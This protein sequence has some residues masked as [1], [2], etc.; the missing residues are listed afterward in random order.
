V[1]KHTVELCRDLETEDFVVQPHWFV[2]PPKWHLGHTTWFFDRF[3][4]QKLLGKKPYREDF[5]WVFNSYYESQG[6]R[7]AQSERGTLSRPTVREVMDYRAAVDE[8]I[9]EASTWL[10]NES[11]ETRASWA[12]A[13]EL[14]RH[15]EQQHQELLVMDIKHI[16]YHQPARPAL[17][18]LTEPMLMAT[19]C[20]APIR[21]AGA[22][23]RGTAGGRSAIPEYPLENPFELSSDALNN[24]FWIDVG[25]GVHRIGYAGTGFA[26]D[27]ERPEHHVYLEPYRIA[28]RL[29]TNGEYLEFMNDGGYHRPELWLSDG[30]RWV[31][32][33]KVMA[34]MY[35]FEQHGQW[36]QYRLNGSLPPDPS[37]AVSHVSFYEAS[38]FAAW[39][40][41]RLPT[42]AEWETASRH[43]GQ[44]SLWQ[45]T[46]SSYGPYP[47]FKAFSGDLS[48]YNGKFMCNQQV[49]RGGCWATPA[50]HYRPTYRNFFSPEMRWQFSGIRLAN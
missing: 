21:S 43:F 32:E 48:E 44:P 23:A 22:R 20:P 38:A 49:L 40:G 50:G 14:G 27:N 34:P 13:V 42:E 10:A 26:F 15:H 35:W 36:L 7:V 31:T 25:S 47:G 11:P 39:A 8:Q 24:H 3:C 5:D 6:A 12:S 45:W 46:Q 18:G 2:S 1:R 33:N 37:A 17:G 28:E 29:V 9:E 19:P 16:L 30:W 41:A 4:L